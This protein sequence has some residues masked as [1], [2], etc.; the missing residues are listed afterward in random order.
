[1]DGGVFGKCGGGS[2][3]HFVIKVY[4]SEPFAKG[5]KAKEIKKYSNPAEVYRLASK[6]LGKT[7]KIGLSPRRDKKYMVITPEGRKVHFGQMGFEDYSHHKNKTRRKNYLTRSGKIKGDWAKDKY[8][9]N[10][11]ARRLL[12]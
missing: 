6:Y 10:N 2:S 5:A 8:S 3:R 4:M 7:A 9:A 1:M 11:L 12:W